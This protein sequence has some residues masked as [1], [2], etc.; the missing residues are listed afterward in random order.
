MSWLRFSAVDKDKVSQFT[1]WIQE[2]FDSGSPSFLKKEERRYRGE[3][4]LVPI[5]EIDWNALE[6]QAKEFGLSPEDSQHV[7][8]GLKRFREREIPKEPIGEGFERVES[9]TEPERELTPAQQQRDVALKKRIEEYKKTL[10]PEAQAV[11]PEEFVEY[12]E[13]VRGKPKVVE[14]WLQREKGLGEESLE[15]PTPEEEQIARREPVAKTQMEEALEVYWR[16]QLELGA[17]KKP[18]TLKPGQDIFAER[19]LIAGGLRYNPET[20]TWIPNISE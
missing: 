11:D 6:G 16:E 20:G 2:Q 8:L 10:P 5:N 7:F 9:P 12:L 19:I 3:K 4:Y 18:I 14:E 17:S 15:A 13:K 1:K